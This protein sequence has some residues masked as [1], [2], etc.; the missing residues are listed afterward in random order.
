MLKDVFTEILSSKDEWE[1]SGLQAKPG[2]LLP[3]RP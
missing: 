1:E 3:I 2:M